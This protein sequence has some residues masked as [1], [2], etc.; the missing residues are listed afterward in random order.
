[1]VIKNGLLLQLKQKARVHREVSVWNSRRIILLTTMTILVSHVLIPTRKMAVMLVEASPTTRA[2]FIASRSVHVDS[3]T[4][5]VAR[6]GASTGRTCPSRG[7]CTK[8]Y[9]HAS[10]PT[11]KKSKK[12]PSPWAH[13][14][15]IQKRQERRHFKEQV[16]L[17]LDKQFQASPHQ[18]QE[19]YFEED[20][21]SKPKQKKKTKT[22]TTK[23]QLYRAD[24]VLANRSG[25]TRTECSKLLQRQAISIL[26]EAEE[27]DSQEEK[28]FS[29]L[30]LRRLK[31]PKEK[32]PM[33]ARI[34]INQ[35]FEVPSLPPLLTVFHKPK[36]VL[37]TMGLDA[38]DR[39]NL[40]LFN[41]PHKAQLHPVGRL[42]YDSSGLLLF[43]SS[44]TLTQTL[45]HPKYEK[46]KEY[47][48]TVV[49]KVQE[50]VLRQK[51]QSGVELVD[52]SHSARKGRS[53]AASAD[54]MKLDAAT[55]DYD[56]GNDNEGRGDEMQPTV[57]S[58]QT[59]SSK[60]FTTR[61]DILHVRHWPSSDV[62]PYMQEVRNTL[63][64]EYNTTDLK[65]RG[66]LDIL[67]AQELSD[68]RL[69]VSE[70]KHRMVRRMLA[71]CGHPVVALKRERIGAIELQ[72]LPE[73]SFRNLTMN[74]QV[75]AESLVEDSS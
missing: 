15:I 7:I 60:T 46:E 64:P 30:P 17:L 20:E 24:R 11:S 55:D 16:S 70:G 47:V 28:D 21:E 8:R 10:G 38:R 35:K 12:S 25:K 54:G 41:F 1:M 63:P 68:V 71:T 44:G 52:V 62:N 23:I 57:N 58:Q 9:F 29:K 48:A 59:K 49:G 4:R 39:R 51:L 43:S 14:E 19:Q 50:D 75:W 32:I 72:D 31:G 33:N 74:E 73:G 65:L 5:Q 13:Q 22:K 37:S 53:A 45:L 61:A 2:A 67:D 18:Q 40:Q 42:D 66:Y 34:F 3:F 26:E 27:G 56:T 36:W 6:A 69:V